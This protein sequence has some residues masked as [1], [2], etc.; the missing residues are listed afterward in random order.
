MRLNVQIRGLLASYNK[1]SKRFLSTLENIKFHREILFII[2]HTDFVTQIPNAGS[3]INSKS[4]KS[5]TGVNTT[6][7]KEEISVEKNT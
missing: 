6:D 1:Y 2:E 7:L 3:D 5:D 4:K